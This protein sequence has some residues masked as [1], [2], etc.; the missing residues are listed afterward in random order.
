M[1]IDRSLEDSGN[2][3]SVI[4]TNS[5]ILNTHLTK[6]IAMSLELLRLNLS[7]V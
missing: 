6:L 1:G 2:D 5:C 7:N 3:K 4:S